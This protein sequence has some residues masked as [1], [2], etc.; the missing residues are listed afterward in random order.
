MFL[1]KLTPNQTKHLLFQQAKHYFWTPY[2]PCSFWMIYLWRKVVCFVLFCFLV[3]RSTKPG[4][5]RLCSWYLW[6]ALDEEGCMGLV[7]WCLVLAVQ[8]FLIIEWLLHW[9]FNSNRSWKFWRNWNVPLVLLE[10]SW[11]AGFNGILFGKAWIQTC[12]E[13]LI[14]KWF[15]LLKNSNKLQK[16]PSFGRKNQLRTWSLLGQWH[17]PY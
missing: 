4:C 5:F 13:I 3:M 14:L 8:K 9:K 15:L 2:F 6:K 11:W 12:R 17:G 10:R 7:P 1:K 16:K